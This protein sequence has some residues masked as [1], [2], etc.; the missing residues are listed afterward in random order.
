MTSHHNPADSARSTT[1]ARSLP[2]VVSRFIAT[3]T[4]SGVL[5]VIAGLIALCWANSP[6]GDAYRAL[7]RTAIDLQVGSYHLHLDLR[8]AVNDGLMV[9]FFFVVGLEIKRELVGGELSSPR[10]AA[11]PVIAAIGGMAVPAG[12]FLIIA[13]GGDAANGWGIPMATDIAFALAVLALV[14][15]RVPSAIKLIVLTFAIVDDIGA[16]A[17]IAIFYSDSIHLGWLALAVAG[18]VL[19][20]G[21]RR[22]RVDWVPIY[23]ALAFAAWL[24]AFESGVHATI[25]GVALALAT[26][27]KALAPVEA[28]SRWV[29]RLTHRPTGELA[30]QLGIVARS[31]ASPAEYLEARLHPATSLIILPLFALA[32]SGVEINSNMLSGVT[33]QRV[34]LGVVVGLVVGKMGGIL[35]ATYIGKRLG[36]LSLPA[37][38]GWFDIA[39]VGA[40][41]GIGF[42][43]SLFVAG[44]AF[45]S[46]ASTEA[47]QLGVLVASG[48][49]ATLACVLVLLRP[50]PKGDAAPD[51]TIAVP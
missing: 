6:W 4:A 33:Q 34:F 45:E 36:L 17:V 28:V 24:G 9:L 49:A 12:L 25:A 50:R 35:L 10:V 11:L 20:F 21:L 40:L 8:H 23:L 5:L 15:H 22:A 39:I 38:V 27:T 29:D 16:I 47:A 3:E 13:G 37:G 46:V 18:V 7:W 42:T 30:N 26:P 44:L 2:Q 41:G 14:G 48:A 51:H 43:V 31:A 1:P 19:T 32:N